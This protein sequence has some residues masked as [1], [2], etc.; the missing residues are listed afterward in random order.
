MSASVGW[1]WLRNALRAY[2]IVVHVA[3][4][5]WRQ[6][7]R[8]CVRCSVSSCDFCGS[9]GTVNGSARIR[10]Q[11]GPPELGLTARFRHPASSVACQ[12]TPNWRAPFQPLEDSVELANFLVPASQ[13]PYEFAV[14]GE[15]PWWRAARQA[16]YRL[17]NRLDTI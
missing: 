6:G 12:A 1:G 14:D 2:C 7:F 15:V 17:G 5:R 9:A 11:T 8:N 3:Y 4:S 13:A 16:C 10:E